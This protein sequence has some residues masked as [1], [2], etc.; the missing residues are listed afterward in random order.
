MSGT[1]D[2][3]LPS[4]EPGISNP[5]L[6]EI[7]DDLT[8]KDPEKA[9]SNTSLAAPV[10]NLPPDGGTQAWLVVLGGFCVVFASFGWINCTYYPQKSVR[11]RSQINTKT[12]IGVFQDFYQN[13]QLSD[14]SPS[15]VAW[16][17]ATE[18]FF[19]FFCVCTVSPSLSAITCE[20]QFNPC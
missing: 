15:T 14:Y 8:N 1:V 7:D 5:E 17:P 9:A 19:M 10:P 12:G 4:A 13:H 2:E 11:K 16:I 3:P 20:E 6:A 18:S